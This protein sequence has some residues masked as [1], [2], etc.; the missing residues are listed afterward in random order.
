MSFVNGVCKIQCNNGWAYVG[1]GKNGAYRLTR[2]KH[3][4]RSGCHSRRNLQRDWDQLGPDAF[5]FA[6]VEEV[7]PDTGLLD[8]AESR[9]LSQVKYCYNASR[10]ANRAN[11]IDR[12]KQRYVPGPNDHVLEPIGDADYEE[13]IR[14]GP[15]HWHPSYP[16]PAEDIITILLPHLYGTIAR[17]QKLLGMPAVKPDKEDGPGILTI[18]ID[19]PLPG[20]Y[21]LK[22]RQLPW[23]APEIINMV[24]VE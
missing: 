4:L 14:S 3:L 24:P 15:S 20:C 13:L 8:E 16:P 2:H 10:M 21:I 17:Q 18:P 19:V 22:L 9:H 23:S 1:S 11:R 12:S 5:T 7:P 6:L